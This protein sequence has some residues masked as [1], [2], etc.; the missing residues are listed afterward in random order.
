MDGVQEMAYSL[1]ILSAEHAVTSPWS[2]TDMLHPPGKLRP[3]Q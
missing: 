2:Q 3:S 1:S